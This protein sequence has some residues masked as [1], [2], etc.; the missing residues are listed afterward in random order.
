MAV[1][2]YWANGTTRMTFYRALRRHA[3]GFDYAAPIHHMHH[4][5]HGFAG[6]GSRLV[7]IRYKRDVR[8]ALCSK[9]IPWYL[10][11]VFSVKI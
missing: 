9:C 5:C 8:I 4:D 2:F 1:T 6:T 11:D 10:A 7:H 3:S